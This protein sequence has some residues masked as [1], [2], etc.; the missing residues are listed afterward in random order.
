MKQVT[1]NL[2]SFSELCNDSKEKAISEHADFLAATSEDADNY[3]REDIVNEIE[4][5]EYLF[6]QSGE[7]SSCTTYTGK[8]SK[9]GIT[10]LKLGGEVYTL[11][12]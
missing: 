8:H 4:I 10:E 3:T 7:L 6:F 1:I 9:S 5:N 12:A 11:P 2:Y